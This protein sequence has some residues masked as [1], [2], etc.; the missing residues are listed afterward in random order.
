MLY[1]GSR[2]IDQGG[3]VPSKSTD[4]WHELLCM[5]AAEVNQHKAD[6]TRS[7]Q[8]LSPKVSTETT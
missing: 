6:P 5:A 1:I 2:T 3:L 8:P 4:H 7:A